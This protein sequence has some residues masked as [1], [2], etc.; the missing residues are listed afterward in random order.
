MSGSASSGWRPVA[1][2]AP[3]APGLLGA[4]AAQ[5]ASPQAG[6]AHRNEEA[7][8]RETERLAAYAASLHYDD[9]PTAVVQRAKDCIADTVAAIVYGA[10]LPWRKIIIA[11]TRRNSAAGKSSILG[12]SG[13][14]V[15]A[16][17]AAL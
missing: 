12:T 13:A 4:A 15:H 17:A 3:L 9:L 6:G 7:S 1:G 8:Q 2:A 14:P 11:H 10:E 5:T 16:G